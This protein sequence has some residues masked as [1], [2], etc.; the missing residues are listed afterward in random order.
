MLGTARAWMHY[1]GADQFQHI[2]TGQI[3]GVN[4]YAWLT[5]ALPH[6]C[7]GLG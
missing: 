2:D 6:R 4:Q 1:R 3:L 7:R 5:A